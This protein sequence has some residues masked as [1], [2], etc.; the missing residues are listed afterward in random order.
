MGMSKIKMYCVF[1]MYK[2]NSAPKVQEISWKIRKKGFKIQILIYDISLSF[3][4]CRY[5]CIYIVDYIYVHIFCIN[6]YINTSYSVSL[7]LPI[8]AQCQG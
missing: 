4:L 8:C 5:M 3:S 2:D 1:C 7:M 6:K